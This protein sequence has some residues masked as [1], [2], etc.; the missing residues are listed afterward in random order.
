MVELLSQ[1]TSDQVTLA[2]GGQPNP[3]SICPLIGDDYLGVVVPIRI[4]HLQILALVAPGV[5]NL[6]PCGSSAA[7]AEPATLPPPFGRPRARRTAQ[8]GA[9]LSADRR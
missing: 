3:G 6:R 7:P 9:D 5:P 2:L 8:P 1:M 4:C